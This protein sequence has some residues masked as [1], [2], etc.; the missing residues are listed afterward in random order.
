MVVLGQAVDSKVEPMNT[1]SGSADPNKL[2]AY[3]CFN[4]LPNFLPEHID[5]LAGGVV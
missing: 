2:V 1:Q 3:T 5:L 4:F